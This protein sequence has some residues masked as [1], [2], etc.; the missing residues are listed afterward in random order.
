MR[1]LLI[2]GLTAVCTALPAHAWT[3]TG[4]CLLPEEDLTLTYI[5]NG[6]SVMSSDFLSSI[7]GVSTLAL[8]QGWSEDGIPRIETS[9][10]TDLTWGVMAVTLSD[11]VLQWLME[12]DLGIEVRTGS[13]KSEPHALIP[14]MLEP[15][16]AWNS[17]RGGYLERNTVIAC[18]RTV[19]VPAGSF[20]G[21]VMISSVRESSEST[22]SAVEYIAPGIGRIMLIE[23]LSAPGSWSMML[24]HRLDSIERDT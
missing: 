8:H 9:I 18:D 6:S 24:I 15:G 5:I 1:I 10:I 19:T 20:A 11:T 7:S 17:I 2:A 4:S 21:C 3:E 22:R 16:V 13:H 12:T 23:E 14:L